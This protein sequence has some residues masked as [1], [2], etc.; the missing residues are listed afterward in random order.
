[1]T[2]RCIASDEAPE[3]NIQH[4]RPC[5]DCPFARTAL[6][7]WLGGLTR[8]EWVSLLHSDE[9]IDCHAIIGPQCAGAAIYRANICKLPR[10][11]TL[12]RL[13]ADRLLVFG[14]PIEFAEHHCDTSVTATLERK[15]G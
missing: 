14:S 15:E 7:G 6:A 4:T 1:M 5:T 2:R 13:Q 12:L 3:S 9:R 10:D 8:Q 11:K